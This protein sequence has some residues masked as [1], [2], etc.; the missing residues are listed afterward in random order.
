[1]STCLCWEAAAWATQL[2]YALHTHACA[3]CT[4]FMPAGVPWAYAHRTLSACRRSPRKLHALRK[5]CTECLGILTMTT[6]VQC[7]SHALSHAHRHAL[8]TSASLA[9]PQACTHEAFTA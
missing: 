3:Y 5:P 1:M 7:K 9:R 8:S 6:G 4:A 2:S